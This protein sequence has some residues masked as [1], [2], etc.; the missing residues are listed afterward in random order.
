M[1]IR[2]SQS[3]QTSAKKFWRMGIL[4]GIAIALG[5]ASISS[6]VEKEST[7]KIT[8]DPHQKI[9]VSDSGHSSIQFRTRL[10]GLVDIIGWFADFDVV[11]Q[12][13]D[14]DF[15]V[16]KIEAHIRTESVTM[17]N[18]GMSG[19][20]KKE[21][22][23]DTENYPEAIYVGRKVEKQNDSVYVITGELTMKGVT[24]NV[25]LEAQ[26]NG[27]SHKPA[28]SPGFT[29]IAKINRLDFGIGDSE[30]IASNQKP[31]IG[32]TMYLTFNMRFADSIHVPWK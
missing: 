28:G 16:A 23:L 29:A 22:L 10:W 14:N 6:A 1:K 21:G 13:K 15:T 5:F 11:V 26:F 2:L 12:T 4:A 27:F 7:R 25:N 8:R 24:K 31:T 32:D 17:P 30:I 18:S 20:L 19:N 9:W 3:D